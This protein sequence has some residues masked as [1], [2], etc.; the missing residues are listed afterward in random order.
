MNARRTA[1]VAAAA[2]LLSGCHVGRVRRAVPTGTATAATVPSATTSPAPALAA[3]IARYGA[4]TLSWKGC[5]DGFEC[6]R[7]TVPRDYAAPAGG[8]VTISVIR[9]KARQQSRRIGSL[10]LNPGGPGGSGIEFARGAR[11]LLPNEILDRFDTVSF[12]PRGVGESTPVDCLDDAQLDRLVAAD[13]TPD[14]P[15][16]RAA[17]FDL[18]RE[19]A[20]ACGRKSGPLLPFVATVDTAKDLDVLRAA[21]R[22]QK[23]T[24]VGFSYGTLLGARYA[25]QFP[26]HIRALVLDGA[27]DPMLTPRQTTL[28]QALGFERALAAFLADCEQQRCAFASHGPIGDTF[29]TLMARVERDPIPASQYPGRLLGPSEALFGVAAALYSREGGWPLLRD[30]LESAYSAKDASG[31]FA[32][33]DN[34]V[35]RDRD[36]H[37]SNS[38]EAQAAISCVDSAYPRDPAAYDADAVAFKKQA[39]RFGEA[40]AYGPVACAYWPVP[41]VSK[42]GP[43]KAPGAPK[44]LVVGTTRDPATPYAWSVSLAKQLAAELLTHV[45]DGHTAYGYSRS[46]CVDREVDAYLLALALPKPGTR[47]P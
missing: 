27:V 6:A 1:A 45:G 39:P 37:Y 47:C 29:D 26:G 32:L 33:F 31:L 30:A 24:Y 22:D 13:P 15:A 2:L 20:L 9:L 17:L 35:E 28:A 25:E 5:G 41:P 43:V 42:P 36:G 23:L 18:S 3:T 11:Q 44:V 21:L 7:L 4:A 12:D 34:L 38:L 46:S 40:L 14:T 16:E 10:V 19:E 8:D